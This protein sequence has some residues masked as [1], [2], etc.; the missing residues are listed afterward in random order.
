MVSPNTNKRNSKRDTIEK[1]HPSLSFLT[2]L[3]RTSLCSHIQL[4]AY[5][6]SELAPKPWLASAAGA[7]RGEKALC[8]F[9]DSPIGNSP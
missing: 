8:A 7:A 1:G 3:A 9:H 4:R 5:A 6:Y 2:S